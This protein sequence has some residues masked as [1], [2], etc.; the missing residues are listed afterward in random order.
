MIQLT[1][2]WEDSLGGTKLILVSK[3][4]FKEE[5]IMGVVQDSAYTPYFYGRRVESVDCGNHDRAKKKFM[6]AVVDW[7]YSFGIEVTFDAVQEE[8]TKK[9]KSYK[10]YTDGSALTNPGKGGYAGY[11]VCGSKEEK[12]G[13]GKTHTTN[14]RME[15]MA[16]LVGLQKIPDKSKVDVYSD[17]QY[18]VNSINKWIRG[19]ASKGWV[20]S[21]G[22]TVLNNDLWI[23]MLQELNRV[24]VEAHWVKGHNGDKYNELCDADARRH[25]KNA[26]VRDL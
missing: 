5:S 16:V 1:H 12:Y 20:K 25:A 3:K 21:D 18:V 19:W 8:K 26:K 13:G 9:S 15:I 11:I 4:N 2:R 24:S 10:L 23:S 22:N 17:S 14:N 7:Y 6:K